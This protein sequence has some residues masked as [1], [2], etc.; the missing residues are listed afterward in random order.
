MIAE[1]NAIMEIMAEAFDPHWGEA[2][3]RNQVIG[4]LGLPTTHILIVDSEGNAWTPAPETS[5]DAASE[6][7]GFLLS[8]AAP[9]EEELLLVAVKPQFRG[10]G[11][12]AILVD[13]FSEQAAARGA[14]NVFLE[15][16][17]NNDA[18]RL[19]R[20]QGFAPIGCRKNY[21]RLS[22]GTRLDAI[23]MGKSLT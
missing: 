18:E 22:D 17:S 7:A 16:R 6:P 12:G 13:R 21:Y 9:G 3:N 23:T 14:E 15:M 2:W 4:S 5:A 19:Y 1:L 11:L 8:R 10:R 20:A